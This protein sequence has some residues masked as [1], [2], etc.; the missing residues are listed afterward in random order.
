VRIDKAQISGNQ[1]MFSVICFT[2]AS[3]LLTA[4]L[5]TVTMQDSWLVVLI[6]AALCL[7][8]IWLYRTLMVMFPEQN[9][10]QILDEVYGPV[11][12]KIIGISYAWF[13]I[14]LATLNLSDL[15]DFVKLTIMPETPNAALLILC[16][17]VSAWAV[18]YGIRVVTRYSTLFAITAFVILAAS[19]MLVI[20]QINPQNFLPVLDQPP[21]K[22]V[23]GT[24]IIT[25]IPFG[26]LVAFLMII[27]NVKLARRD[28]TKKLLLGFALGGVFLLVVILRD[29][30]VLGNMLPMF[31]LPGLVT[32]RL[33][34]MGV[35]LSRIEILF[36][37]VLI[38]LLFF[39][40]TFLYY[41]SV[42]AVAQLI[43]VKAYRHIVLAAGALMIAYG[44]TLY[45]DSVT[46]AASARETT[47]II[48]TA[49]EILLPLITYIIAK[50]R[51]LP[52]AKEA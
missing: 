33:V 7:P 36:A 14:T 50:L 38:M 20:N 4:F 48:W 24:H 22:Y 23:Q 25:T 2:Q 51:K 43:R 35:A 31:S 30:A 26:E 16:V 44:L 15:G 5:S 47:P 45:P 49:F 37:V 42:V 18:R 28:V 34:N 41:I 21:I 13:F 27:P 29:I 39:K 10:I 8:L 19:V 11:A 9:L 52:K 17:A 3:S 1:F 32:L 46:H 6:G 12:G 40:I